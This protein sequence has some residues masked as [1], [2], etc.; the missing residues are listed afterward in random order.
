MAMSKYNGKK[1]G[2]TIGSPDTTYIASAIKL[3]SIMVE[4]KP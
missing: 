2:E 1:N 4:E 3:H